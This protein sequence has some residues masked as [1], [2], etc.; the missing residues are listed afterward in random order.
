[1]IARIGETAAIAPMLYQYDVTHLFDNQN[2]SYSN[3]V[4]MTKHTWARLANV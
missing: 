4:K 3:Y 1:M 2:Q